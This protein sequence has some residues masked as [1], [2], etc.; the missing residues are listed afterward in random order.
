[1]PAR[2]EPLDLAAAGGDLRQV[3]GAVVLQE[4][5]N[6]RTVGREARPRVVAVQGRQDLRGPA[7]R[8]DQGDLVDGVLD[9]LLRPALQVGDRLAVGAPCGPALPGGVGGRAVEGRRLARRS[10]GRRLDAVAVPVV[11]PVGTWTSL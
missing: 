7:R 10:A 5:E 3:H 11:L 8:R 4:E 9:Q 2:Y 6:R 1:A